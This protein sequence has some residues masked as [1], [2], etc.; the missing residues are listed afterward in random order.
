MV[1]NRGKWGRGFVVALG[2]QY[3]AARKSYLDLFRHEQRIPLGLVQFIPVEN[4]ERIYIAN[5]VA[6]DGIRKNSRDTEQYIS[7]PVLR[8]CLEQVCE[9]ALAK[10][11]SVQMPMVGAGLGGGSWDIISAYIDE[12]FSQYKLTCKIVKLGVS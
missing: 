12:I 5:M 10:R 4:Q 7:Y 11:L 8:N 1:N 9:F 3:P 2:R 6:Q